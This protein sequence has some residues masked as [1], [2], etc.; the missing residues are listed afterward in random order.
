MKSFRPRITFPATATP[1]PSLARALAV[2][3]LVLA[4]PSASAAGPERPPSRLV[5]FAD[6]N[7]GSTAGQAL[8]Q[9]RI[10]GAAQ[11]VCAPLDGRSLQQQRA[12][13]TCVAQAIARAQ[14]ALPA[15]SVAA[16]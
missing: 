10:A 6:L 11:A 8:L 14:S 12:W 4:P 16:R 5:S 15:A 2:A 1:L 3:V 9:R 13:R 7:L